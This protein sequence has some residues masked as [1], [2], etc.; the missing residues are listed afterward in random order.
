MMMMLKTVLT[1]AGLAA[2]LLLTTGAQAQ[3]AGTTSPAKK[4]LIQKALQAQSAGIEAVGTQLAGQTAQQ[5]LNAVGQA[6][7]RV[8]AEKRELLATE[9]QADVKK[10]F[11]EVAPTLRTNALKLGPATLGVALEE[12]FNEDELKTLVAWLESPVSRKY[13][14]ATA[15]SQQALM[16]RVV[17][18]SRPAI[19]PKLKALEQTITRRLGVAPATSSTPNGTPPAGTKK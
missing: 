17:A 4:E 12:K 3:T 13:Q 19:D 1:A 11:D 8:P 2:A 16:Q 7:Q 9:V 15:E 10:F 5:V 18:D 14:Q 6:L